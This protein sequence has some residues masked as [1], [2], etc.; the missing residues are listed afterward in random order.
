MPRKTALLFLLLFVCNLFFSSWNLASA[1]D[2]GEALTGIAQSISIEGEIKDGQIICSAQG[3]YDLCKK[4][5]DPSIYGV[6]N[7]GNSAALENENLQNA[8]LVLKD[9]NANV[10]VNGTNGNINSGDFVTTSKDTPG[11]G[12]K[13]IRNGYVIGMALEGAEFGNPTDEKKILVSLNVHPEL[14]ITDARV[15]LLSLLRDGA[16]AP[17]LVGP[18]ASLRYV[19][20]ALIVI[21]A[22]VLGFVYFGRVARTGVEAIGRNPLAGRLIQVNVLLNIALSIVIILVGLGIAY[23]ILIL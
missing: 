10:I 8:H 4:E 23:L 15:N 17:V 3:G 9:G 7:D 22:F 18:I 12:A 1:Q 11:V 14:G 6:V 21:I 13:G 2:S 5:Y 20:A 16:L 19:L